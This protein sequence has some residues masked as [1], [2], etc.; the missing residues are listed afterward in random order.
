MAGETRMSQPA[1]TSRGRDR[2]NS[3]LDSAREVFEELGYFDTRVA[4]IVAHAKVGHGTFYS[5]FD[6]KDDVLR[7]L[8]DNLVEAT[9]S[10]SAMPIDH[11]GGPRDHLRATIVQFMDA[12]RERAGMHRILVQATS[13][14]AEFLSRRLEIKE[15]FLGRIEQSIV[16]WQQ[17]GVAPLDL[18]PFHAATALGGMV[19]DAAFAQYVLHQPI[20]EQIMIT[21]LTTIWSQTV[22]LP[23]SHSTPPV[24]I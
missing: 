9:Y 11:S 10:A 19:E 5:Y 1:K 16:A 4:D 23:E 7:A 21:T 12:Y 13:Y 14:S 18:D 17:R 2:R 3:L 22:G 15:Q 6:S 20:D 8:I 24:T